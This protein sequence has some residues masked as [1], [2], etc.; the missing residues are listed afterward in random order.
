MSP[1]RIRGFRNLLIFQQLRKPRSHTRKRNSHLFLDYKVYVVYTLDLYLTVYNAALVSVLI[2]YISETEKKKKMILYSLIARSS[3]GM[4]LTASVDTDDKPDV[5]LSKKY[6]KLL[7]KKSKSFPERC[8]V[9]INTKLSIYFTSSLGVCYMA[10][11]ENTYPVVLAFSFLDE[12]VKEFI[13]VYTTQ[14]VRTAVRPYSFI[15]FETTILRNRHRYN[16]PSSLATK[17][18]LADLSEEIKLRPPVPLPLKDIEPFANGFNGSSS[19]LSIISPVGSYQRLPPVTIFDFF[20][21][22]LTIFCGLFNF[23]RAITSLSQSTFEDVYGISPLHGVMFLMETLSQC[24]QVYLLLT[25]VRKKYLLTCF[26][27]L[28]LCMC[29]ALV[30]EVRDLWQSL[31]HVALGSVMTFSIISRRPQKKAPNYNV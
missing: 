15:H 19:P 24:F 25:N 30:W 8:S 9:L 21:T 31:F 11:C 1:I 29:N 14:E 13:T 2:K 20:V 6:L 28:T 5:Q 3:D 10:L 16:N 12:L 23:V 22:L 17:I 27:F 4:P 18:N 26:A 7:A